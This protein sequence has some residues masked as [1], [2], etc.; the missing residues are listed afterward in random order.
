[1]AIIVD[2]PVLIGRGGQLLT[3]IDVNPLGGVRHITTESRL[4]G[5]SGTVCEER[6]HAGCPKTGSRGII[7]R[8]VSIVILGIRV[9]TLSLSF[10]PANAPR[11]MA[12]GCRNWHNRPNIVLAKEGIFQGEHTTHGTSNNGG[13]LLNTQIIQDQ[14][15]NAENEC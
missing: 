1:M 14:F 5:V 9:N 4:E 10:T 15:V 2:S 12:C 6:R 8:I 7:E 11:G 3:A 13:D